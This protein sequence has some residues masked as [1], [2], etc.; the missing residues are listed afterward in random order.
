[1]LVFQEMNLIMKM[2]YV[3][4]Y[5]K[6]TLYKYVSCWI[7]IEG[8]CIASGISY[9]GRDKNGDILWDGVEN[10][11]IWRFETAYKFGHVIAS[12]N[13]CTNKWIAQ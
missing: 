13:K 10:I 12:F 6:I 7:V 4:L 9:N 2:F 3:G 11:G 8:S 5:G 1:M